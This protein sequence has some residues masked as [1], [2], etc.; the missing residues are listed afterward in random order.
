M[1]FKELS[2]ARVVRWRQEVAGDKDESRIAGHLWG[3]GRG[4]CSLFQAFLSRTGSSRLMGCK[5]SLL[6]LIKGSIR[7]TL[8]HVNLSNRVTLVSMHMQ[9][10]E[11]VGRGG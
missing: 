1:R 6:L 3:L 9:I 2:G 8:P 7:C 11:Y 4:S 5:V 10:Q